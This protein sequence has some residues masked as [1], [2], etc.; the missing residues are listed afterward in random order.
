MVLLCHR[1]VVS[2]L[3][4]LVP[5]LSI[6]HRFCWSSLVNGLPPRSNPSTHCCRIII[7]NWKLILSLHVEGLWNNVLNL[8]NKSGTHFN[9]TQHS[10]YGVAR[11]CV[12]C[13]V[14]ST[15]VKPQPCPECKFSC[16]WAFARLLFQPVEPFSPLLLDEYNSVF[17]SRTTSVSLL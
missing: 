4:A 6:C 11:P 3:V 13:T 15:Q 14:S 7:S 17:G 16:S 10:L 2:S 8:E 9:G 5:A 1:S 12:F